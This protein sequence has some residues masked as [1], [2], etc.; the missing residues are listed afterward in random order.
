[1]LNV[2]ANLE[3]SEFAIDRELIECVL[4]LESTLHKL[5]NFDLY[6]QNSRIKFIWL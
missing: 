3:S 2:W 5:R 1:M 4:Q 6:S